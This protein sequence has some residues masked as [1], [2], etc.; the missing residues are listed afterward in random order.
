M[1]YWALA[2]YHFF[3]IE[4]PHVEIKSYKNFFENKNI[5]GRIYISK[6]GINA[7]ISARE[8]DGKKFIEWLKK[9]ARNSELKIKVQLC[10]EHAF[11]KTTVKFKEQLVA[12]DQEVDLHNT[13]EKVSPEKWQKM[14]ENKDAQTFLLDVR[15]AY[16][17]EVG[18][19]Q[20]AIKPKLNFFREFAPYIE[21]LKKMMDPEKDTLMMYCT[22]GIRCEYYSAFLKKKGFKKMCQLDGGVINYGNKVGSKFWQGKLFVFDDR[23]I[24][25]IS[26]DNTETL[27]L[28]FHC[29]KPTDIYYNCANM[30]CN[31][32]F[33]SCRECSKLLKGLCSDSCA[34]GRV[35]PF[36]SSECPV[37]FRRFP[38]EEKLKLSSS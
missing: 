38:H 7:Q 34:Q 29:R 35:R 11:Y 14:L 37:P 36:D 15:N 5:K 30:D 27:S 23:M 2:Y 4:N 18:Y 26:E 16:E 25:P 22:G 31:E 21:E 1:H 6:E 32:L 24:T 3:P 10:K 20:G 8:E 28:C 9:D 17:S 19:F 13:A 12:F 33:L